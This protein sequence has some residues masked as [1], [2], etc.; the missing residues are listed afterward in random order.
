MRR[1]TPKINNIIVRRVDPAKLG[2]LETIAPKL[3]KMSWIATL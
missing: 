1:V 2:I 3:K